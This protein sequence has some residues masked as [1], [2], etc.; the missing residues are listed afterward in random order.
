MTYIA[1]CTNVTIIEHRATTVFA[2]LY[3]SVKKNL[4][5]FVFTNFQYTKLS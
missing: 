4:N 2:A 5:C 1:S 3:G